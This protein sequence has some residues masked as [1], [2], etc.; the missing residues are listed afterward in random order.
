MRFPASAR[1]P[2]GLPARPETEVQQLWDQIHLRKRNS[3]AAAYL[4]IPFCENHCLFCGF[5]QNARRPAAG[6]PY[7]DAVIAQ[8]QCFADS[9]AAEGPPLQ[10]VY[11]GGGTPTALTG[12]DPL[13]G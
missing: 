4:H 9:A 5:Y 8:L 11:L 1:H 13:P 3:R 6:A 12:R 7:V 2:R 10:A